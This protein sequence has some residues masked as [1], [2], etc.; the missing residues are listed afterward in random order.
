MARAT[1][2]A[3]LART[4]VYEGG[5]VDDPQDPGGRTNN[6]VIQ[7]VYTGWRRNKGLPVRDVFLME[8]AER[9]AIYRRQYWDAVSGDDLPPGIDLVVFDGAVNSG[10]AQSIKWLQRALNVKPEGV[11]GEATRAALA[12]CDDHDA[13]VAR[14]CARRL[15]FLKALRTFPRFGKGWTARVENVRRA[16]QAVA[17]GS[18]GPSPVYFLGGGRKA[19]FEDAAPAPV[20]APGDAASG[21]GAVATTLGTVT[22]TLTPFSDTS[23]RIKLVLAI[24][25][26][27]GV[28][29]AACGMLYGRWARR[30]AAARADA[31][32]LHPEA[33][34]ATATDPVGE[35][36]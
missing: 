14:I 28:V 21:G 34:A 27:L 31:L 4:L 6:G 5:K 7:R 29:V 2:P 11:F 13:L 35:A 20:R 32:D 8:P 1:F 36:A 19:P 18:V 16:G 10:P 33:P 3:A 12:A 24:V 22:D 15:V 25:T 26:I 30:R 9:D 23:D 17:S